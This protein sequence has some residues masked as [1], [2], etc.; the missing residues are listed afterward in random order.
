MQRIVSIIA[1]LIYVLASVDTYVNV[2]YCGDS[3]SSINL[4]E[5]TGSCCCDDLH[6][7]E[8]N[9]CSDAVI[10]L[11]VDKEQITP[12]SISNS[13]KVFTKIVGLNSSLV[14]NP[15]ISG[16]DNTRDNL[17]PPENRPLYLTLSSFIFYG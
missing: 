15:K 7:L 5:K 3:L 4:Y 10:Q 12:S 2:H 13:Y 11:D 8:N 1:L 16:S 9:C 17:P 14:E 6:D